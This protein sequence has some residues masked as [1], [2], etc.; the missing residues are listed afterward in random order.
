MLFQMRPNKLEPR[1][2]L[3]IID[4]Q[5]FNFSPHSHS[6]SLHVRLAT[7]NLLQG[8]VA[9]IREYFI[10]EEKSNGISKSAHR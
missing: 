10:D 9:N 2:H 5:V 7:K 6:Y 1:M 8:I 4:G 3:K